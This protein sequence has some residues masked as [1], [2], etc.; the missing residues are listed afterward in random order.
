MRARAEGARATGS[1]RYGRSS[2]QETRANRART[3]S[4][5]LVEQYTQMVTVLLRGNKSALAANVD[6]QALGLALAGVL[7]RA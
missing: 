5:T 2:G 7:I 6:R 4:G 3:L 1:E